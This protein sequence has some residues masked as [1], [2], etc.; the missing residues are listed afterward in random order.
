MVSVIGF[1]VSIYNL[2][3]QRREW[4]NNY[5]VAEL[6]IGNRIAAILLTVAQNML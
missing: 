2:K 5:T 3:S 6:A 4:L 1:M